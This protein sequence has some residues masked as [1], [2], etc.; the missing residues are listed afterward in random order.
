MWKD[1]KI[2]I[3]GSYVLLSMLVFSTF[4]SFF[5]T[6]IQPFWI[7][8]LVGSYTD[9]GHLDLLTLGMLFGFLILN[10]LIGALINYGCQL[11]SQ[12]FTLNYHVLA[13]KKIFNLSMQEMS[14]YSNGE[15]TSRIITDI[16][17][18]RQIVSQSVL[19]LPGAFLL[20]IASVIT[21]LLIDWVLSLV[22]IV[23]LGV[24]LLITIISGKFINNI[25]KSIQET[26]SKI[27]QGIQRFTSNVIFV[28]SNNLEEK[29][30]H[31]YIASANELF[32]SSR[33]FARFMSALTPLSSLM[34]NGL[35]L[36][37]VIIGGVRVH[38]SDLSYENLAIII[39]FLFVMIAPLSSATT[40]I[41]T[42]ASATAAIRR[43]HPLISSQSD[44]HIIKDLHLDKTSF[45]NVSL[46]FDGVSVRYSEDSLLALK[47]LTFQTPSRGLVAIVG[48]SGIG[49]TTIALSTIGL[50]SPEKGVI[51]LNST[52]INDL[53]GSYI[54]EHL[55]TLV[56][57]NAPL[58]GK[59]VRESITLGKNISD[60]KVL[61][62]MR[63]LNLE[64]FLDNLPLGLD[65]EISDVI[66]EASAGQI[67]RLSFIRGILRDTPILILDEPTS[68]LD[69]D[70]EGLVCEVIHELSE[71]KLVIVISHRKAPTE[72]ATMCIR[73][74]K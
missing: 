57:Q 43:L 45:S 23:S 48:P 12:R 14:N 63:K 30:L 44:K 52:D 18:A 2:S 40:A 65:S 24:L 19:S 6:Y 58:Y 35:I 70:S 5:V 41:G 4:L 49:K 38:S 55:V 69:D 28:K 66:S 11:L 27:G 17:V 31:S 25:T 34:A 72:D 39:T 67:Q 60:E 33:H 54:R 62:W 15:L 56:L 8:K 73:L 10:S 46:S 7:G 50:L 9:L 51:R 61:E 59:N 64:Q 26:Y 42:I 37:V 13:G 29:S 32:F 22:I 68:N 53:E 47:D 74:D 16:S 1:I 21:I 3:R 20:V 36:I 71:S